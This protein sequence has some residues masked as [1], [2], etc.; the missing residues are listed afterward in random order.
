MFSNVSVLIKFICFYLGRVIFVIIPFLRI[1]KLD[2]KE[3]FNSKQDYIKEIIKTYAI[4]L[5]FYIPIAL[6]VKL[7]AGS[8]PTN[9]TNIKEIPLWITA[10]LAIG[11]APISEEILFRGFL[12][13]IFKNDWLFIS[14]SGILFGVDHCLYA[15]SNLLM[16]LYILPYTVMGLGFAKLYS[17]TNNIF[18]NIILHFMW[19]L[20]AMGCMLILYIG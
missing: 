7:I 8:E 2:V 17:K 19:N 15:E 1:L 4:T 18:A 12:R 20:I 9:Q 5:L 3:F 11:I 14:I 16:Y 13:K 6:I 10:I